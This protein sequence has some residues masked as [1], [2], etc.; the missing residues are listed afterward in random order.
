ML[1]KYGINYLIGPGIG[2]ETRSIK[3]IFGY[4]SGGP[5]LFSGKVG[6]LKPG[7]GTGNSQRYQGEPGNVTGKREQLS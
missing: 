3:C 4:Q 2:V 7:L 1:I 5:L 6:S